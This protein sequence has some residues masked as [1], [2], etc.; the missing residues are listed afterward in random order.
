MNA[1]LENVKPVS[2]YERVVMS[3]SRF[4]ASVQIPLRDRMVHGQVLLGTE[5]LT[6]QFRSMIFSMFW[7]MVCE[8]YDRDPN[9]E[10]FSAAVYHRMFDSRILCLVFDGYD[11]VALSGYDVVGF[12]GHKNL[13]LGIVAVAPSQS[14]K[15]YMG[16]MLRA[17]T[18]DCDYVVTRTQNPSVVNA[19]AGVYGHAYPFQ[20]EKGRWTMRHDYEKRLFEEIAEK[21]GTTEFYDD[22]T[23]VFY[24]VY[25]NASL[26]GPKASNTKRTGKAGDNILKLIDPSKGDAVMAVS[27]VDRSLFPDGGENH[28][29]WYEARPELFEE[30]E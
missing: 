24:G 2:E 7:P 16:G 6:Q 1:V 14:G 19:M 8:A 17:L 25:N 23:C 29:E 27:R 13:Y 12:E 11:P 10:W 28:R 5:N 15:G 26:T 9:D 21:T 30:V 22:R 20:M 4:G 18:G 3:G